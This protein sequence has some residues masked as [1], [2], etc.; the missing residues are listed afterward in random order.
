MTRLHATEVGRYVAQSGLLPETA[1]Y[2]TDYVQR[3]CQ[4]LLGALASDGGRQ[5][6]FD[7]LNYCLINVCLTS[8]EFEGFRRTRFIHYG[9]DEIVQ[10]PLVEQWQDA[11]AEQ[12]WQPYRA[13]ANAAMLLMEWIDG[14][15]IGSVENRFRGVRAGVVQSLAR[16]VSWVLSGLANVLAAA[17][18]PGLSPAERSRPLQAATAETIADMRQFLPALRLLVWRLNVGL[19]L[20]VLWMTE[21]RR[22]DG[23]RAISRGEAIAL[24]RA[25]LASFED[26]RQ[27]RRWLD[28]I[29]AFGGTGARDANARAGEL[30]QLAHSWH[31][32]VR[33]RAKERQMR[34]LEAVDHPLLEHFYESRGIPF[35]NAFENLLARASIG[36][37]KFDDGTRPGAFDYIVIIPNRPEFIVECKTKE[38][39]TFVDLNSARVVLS[40]SEQYG[41]GGHFCVT[42][43]QPGIDPNVPEALQACSRLSVVE[44]QDIAEAL[45]RL[46]RGT[47]EPHG[48][49]DWLNQPGQAKAET[50][51]NYTPSDTL[52]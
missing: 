19:P 36:F 23:R 8:P 28:I 32:T 43:C 50:L 45:I 24:A 10:N 49:H 35:E 48:F 29:T 44:T 6:Q 18:R 33:S 3:R 12:V 38:G 7:Q 26:L 13:A 20:S 14:G 52:T 47:M 51:S 40:S 5:P 22:A 41:F 1:H 15:A 16:D 46:I 34:R 4:V 27:R 25:G 31:Q 17:T 11:L 37:S 39:N 21:L 9:F 42:L 2:L 30:Q